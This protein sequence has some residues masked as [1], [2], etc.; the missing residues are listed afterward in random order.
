MQKHEREDKLNE[1]FVLK[2]VIGG[3]NSKV[4]FFVHVTFSS[5]SQLTFCYTP[6][7]PFTLTHGH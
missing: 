4:F 2:R 5:V 7:N 3:N 6:L 1:R